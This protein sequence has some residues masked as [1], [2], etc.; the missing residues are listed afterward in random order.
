MLLFTTTLLNVTF[1]N[2]VSNLLIGLAFNYFIGELF[3][4]GKRHLKL[5]V[6]IFF[7]VFSVISE[8]LTAVLSGL[9][10]GASIIGIRDNIMHLF[11]GGVVSK[12]LL[13][14][15]FESVVKISKKNASE[16]SLKSWVLIMSIPVVSIILAILV[17]YEPIINNVFSNTAV[18]ACL[19]I[20]YIDLI[21]FY[22]FDN[23]VFQ[24]HENNVIRFR[25]KQLILQHHQ[26]E[27]IISGHEKIKR[28]RH[29][30]LGHLITINEYL[31]TKNL[32]EAKVYIG[33][34]HHEID[35][36][37]QGIFSENIGVDAIINNR[38]AKADELNI[39]TSL[40]VAIPKSLKIDDL[41]LCVVIGNLLTNAIEACQRM[42]KDS[43]RSIHFKMKFKRESIIIESK[44]TYNL[45][46]I[47]DKNGRL[48]S[49]KA[50]REN[51]EIGLGL[52]NI[53]AVT[54]KYDGIFNLHR[55]ENEF[56]V[57]I[58]IPDKNVA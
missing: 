35:F 33:K 34:L 27:N 23:I 25:E 40:D 10:F 38:I 55:D 13:I 17:V 54:K 14:L 22:L 46:T 18:L 52:G 21:S 6:A 58:I 39:K 5:T 20:L 15:F 30:M 43:N 48:I 11:L 28:L 41:D 31:K 47:K 29:D 19:V 45:Q 50:F 53:E 57:R 16:V 36:I 51:N 9:V 3:Y 7:V 44:N 56:V 8:L 4:C 42:D 1:E 12:C 32:E 49:S 37:K 24:I 2:L 26:Y